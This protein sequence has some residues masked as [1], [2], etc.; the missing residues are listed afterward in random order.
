MKEEKTD[1]DLYGSY[2]RKAAFSVHERMQM[3]RI[4]WE[5]VMRSP[6]ISIMM[7]SCH[8]PLTAKEQMKIEQH[9]IRFRELY[10]KE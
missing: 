4:L 1:W 2:A 10:S 9:M 3:Q 6:P 7:L 5:R 8:R